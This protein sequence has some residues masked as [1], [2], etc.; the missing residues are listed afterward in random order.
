LSSWQVTIALIEAAGTSETS[1]NFYEI[2]QRHSPEDS[3]LLLKISSDY[4]NTKGKTSK[5]GLKSG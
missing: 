3:H 4:I 2:V 5:Q 1:V